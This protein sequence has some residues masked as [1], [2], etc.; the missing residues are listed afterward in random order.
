MWFIGPFYVR[1]ARPATLRARRPHLRSALPWSPVSAGTGGQP[2]AG[3]GGV[4]ST[5][6]PIGAA[7]GAYISEIAT[8]FVGGEISEEPFPTASV[9]AD[10]PAILSVSG[11]N[12][13]EDQAEIEIEVD[14]P[15][16][17]EVIHFQQ[18]TTHVAI[19]V[20]PPATD[21]EGN[22]NPVPGYTWEDCSAGMNCIPACM[23]PCAL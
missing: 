8:V 19:E 14:S 21:Y 18:G 10:A 16:A 20:L 1:S 13:D 15:Y 4:P 7:Q 6:P 17:P 22:P 5:E 2:S 9:D 11:I 3:T 23:A 12:V